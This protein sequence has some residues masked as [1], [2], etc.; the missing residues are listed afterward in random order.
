MPILVDA[1][2]DLA[3]NI[4]TLKRDYTRSAAETRVLEAGG[5]NVAHNGNT[6]LGW[7]D[8]QRAQAAVV[9]STL[10]VS[11]Q[12]RKLG[13]W[14]SQSYKD[15]NE[16]YHRYHAQLDTYHRLTDQHP[17][18]FRLIFTGKD[19][20]DVLAHWKGS[21]KNHPV[22]ML[23]LMEGAEGIRKPAELE[24]WWSEGVRI[25]GPAWAGTRFCG[26]TREPGPLTDDGRNLLA[27]MAE[28]G[29]TLD[30]SHMDEL[31]A[32][33]ALDDYPGPIIVSHA[34]SAALMSNYTG[35]RLLTDGVI[36]KTIERDGIIGLVPVLP[37][38]KNGW[39]PAN[40]RD[41]LTLE[42]IFVPQIDHICQMAGNAQHVGLG[43]DFDGG[44]G[45][46][47]A[48]ADVNTIADL[49]KLEPILSAR[50]YSD[51]DIAAI[52]GEN[53]LRHLQETLPA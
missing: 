15:F 19:L 22:G 36:K 10:F 45:V 31:A 24:E 16:A 20:D 27:G 13:D 52:M 40:G 28:I 50:G 30:L 38:L 9:F 6:M 34:N 47:A 35:N 4:L 32:R 29:M 37:F 48:P 43:T 26:G 23:V 11:P 5:E 44:F 42:S 7:D 46:E 49:Q 21:Q 3:W 25:I 39:V 12:R 33:Q 51:T 18:K 41:G 8:Y 53:W 1:H 14:D 17:D 2:E